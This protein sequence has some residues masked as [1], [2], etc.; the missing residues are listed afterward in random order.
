MLH[1]QYYKDYGLALEGLV[2]FHHIDALKYNTEVD[3]ALP[4]EHILRSDPALRLLLQSFDRKR[5]RSCGFSQMLT[6]HMAA[7]AS[8]FLELTTFLMASHTATMVAFL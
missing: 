2:R 3:D 1:Q 5:S 7:G 4:L 8:N 6:K